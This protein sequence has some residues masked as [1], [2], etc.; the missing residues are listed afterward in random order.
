[1]L[2]WTNI[3]GQGLG[4]YFSKE[5]VQILRDTY[6]S[7]ILDETT[8][9]ST[10]KQLGICVMY[11][12]EPTV[13]PVKRFLDMVEVETVTAVGLYNAIKSS[14]EEKNV[15]IKNITG[16]SLDTTNV[17]FGEYQSVVSLL[18]K[19]VSYVLAVKC[20]CHMI[21]LCASYACLK[22]STTLE[23]LC[24]NIY[25]YFSR[26]S[27]RQHE[28]HEFQKFVETKLHKVLGIGQTRWLSLESCV[29][30]VLE[31]WEAL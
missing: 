10:Q 26:S 17:M 20:S 6:F 2:R 16:F 23:D 27:L 4:L 22:K 31:Q 1:M 18:K 19:D 12:E 30:R 8:D 28:F 15:P 11:F 5:L 13:Q 3:L 25:S 24:R 29:K 14:F 21:H 9:V 7:I